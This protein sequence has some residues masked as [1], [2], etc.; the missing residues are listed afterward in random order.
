MP[1]LLAEPLRQVMDPA[2]D[3]DTAYGICAAALSNGLFTAMQF[4]PEEMEVERLYS[5]LPDVYPV[6]G[7]KPK[8]ATEW[9]GKGSHQRKAQSRLRCRGYFLGLLRP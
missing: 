3:R 1:H 2:T 8:K 7:R 5:T 6:S 4:H 9:G